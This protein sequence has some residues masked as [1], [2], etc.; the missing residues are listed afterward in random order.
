[1]LLSPKQDVV[2]SLC[3]IWLDQSPLESLPSIAGEQ[4][5]LVMMR[6]AALKGQVRCAWPVL[7]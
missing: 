6:H 5:A 1:M 2:S 7:K 4:H 3:F